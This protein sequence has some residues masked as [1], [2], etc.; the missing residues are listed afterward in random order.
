MKTK[1]IF[2][3]IAAATLLGGILLIVSLNRK[4][5]RQSGDLTIDGAMVKEVESMVRLCSMDI[6]EETPV[7]ATI[8]N[9]HLFGR[10]TLKGSITFDLERIVLKM[11]GDTLR[12]Q[13]PPEK[14]E[15]LESTDKDSYIVIDT[16]NDR[17]MGSG[18][19]TTAEENK[20]KEKVKQNAI[21]SIYRKGYVKRARAEAAENLT[22][23]L[24]A[25]TS[26]PVVVT[27]PT[28][29]GNLR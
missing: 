18:S 8:G 26:K 14:V 6:Y 25:L 21:K 28:P 9:R 27:D 15:I 2:P 12:V 24:S 1:K 23:M 19:F 29:E 16:W 10:I 7:K 22:A 20:I 4:S 17:F 3:I 13:L 11:S 5:S